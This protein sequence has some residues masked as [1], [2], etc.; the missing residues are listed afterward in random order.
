MENWNRL[1]GFPKRPGFFINNRLSSMVCVILHSQP[2]S[3]LQQ[4]QSSYMMKLQGLIA[5]ARSL[6][7]GCRVMFGFDVL[8]FVGVALFPSPA[9]CGSCAVP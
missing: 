7:D 1:C 3:S 5:T 8:P 9:S 2:P 4:C 6:F